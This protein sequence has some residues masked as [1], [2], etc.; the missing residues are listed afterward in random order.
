MQSK[1]TRAEA[2]V[3]HTTKVDLAKHLKIAKI[4]DI[5]GATLPA[6]GEAYDSC[7]TVRFKVKCENGHEG[8]R[9]NSCNRKECP[10]CSLKL[11][12]IHI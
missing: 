8:L 2:V 12:L 3:Y 9:V 5:P 6:Y 1:S 11:S 10:V 4:P 7:G